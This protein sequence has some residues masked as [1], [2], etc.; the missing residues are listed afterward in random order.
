M[1][2]LDDLFGDPELWADRWSLDRDGQ[3]SYGVA[4]AP[5]PQ[6]EGG[7]HGHEKK[8][9]REMS[10]SE[11]SQIAGGCNA[12]ELSY[13]V[14]HGPEQAL[15]VALTNG[16]MERGLVCYMIEKRSPSSTLLVAISKLAR[17]ATDPAVA[18]ALCKSQKTPLYVSRALMK[19]CSSS[20]INEI[21]RSP[22]LPN[23]LRV[24]AR[25]IKNKGK[26]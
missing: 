18:G 9:I 20:D 5:A 4:V 22:S 15:V 16:S 3:P 25:K 1:S 13:I 14:K 7:G 21:T 24:M 19:R 10:G 6:S 12:K 11:L 17:F 26:K 23:S 2:F 8:E